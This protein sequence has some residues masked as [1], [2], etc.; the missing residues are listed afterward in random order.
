MVLEPGALGYVVRFVRFPQGMGL[1]VDG[2]I[3]AVE[4]LLVGVKLR[5]VYNDVIV[6]ASQGPYRTELGH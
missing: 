2:S 4:Q 3:G 1:E 5:G 6:S